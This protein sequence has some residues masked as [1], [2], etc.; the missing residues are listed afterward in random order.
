MKNPE[1]EF[2]GM[3]DDEGRLARFAFP[4]TGVCPAVL[5]AIEGDDLA[6][7]FTVHAC[8]HAEVST[9]D[10]LDYFTRIKDGDG[11]LRFAKRFGVLSLCQHG[12]YQHEE[13][14][15]CPEPRLPSKLLPPDGE[16]E[17]FLFKEP[18]SGWHRHVEVVNAILRVAADLHQFKS[19]STTDWQIIQA[20]E[21]M[22]YPLRRF[23]LTPDW[24]GLGFVLNEWLLAGNISPEF[25]TQDGR[26]KITF[27]GDTWS[28]LGFQVALSITGDGR[29]AVCDGCNRV[30]SRL[31]KP[32]RSRRNFCPVCRGAGI[33]NKLRQ[34]TYAANKSKTKN[35][36]K[37]NKANQDPGED[38]NG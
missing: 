4:L 1:W 6:W 7:V 18:L 22:G 28:T 17:R 3:T 31:R 29:T 16:E 26:P 35:S 27:G 36:S 9:D 20:N 30:Y 11:V 8:Y 13:N 5:S 21:L 34:R 37:P 19:P 33:D 38:S 23:G 25:S 32:Q 12:Y 2:A 24:R 15:E 14:K 10:M